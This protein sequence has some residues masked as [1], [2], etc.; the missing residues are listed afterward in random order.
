MGQLQ[1]DTEIKFNYFCTIPYSSF[2]KQIYH[3]IL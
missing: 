2:L 3:K 1:L